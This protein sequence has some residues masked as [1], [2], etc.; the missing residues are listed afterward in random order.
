MWWRKAPLLAAA[1]LLAACGFTPVY[2]P[3]G[4]AL[5]FRGEVR[6][7]APDTEEEFAFN[8][9]IEQRLGRPASP[10]YDLAYVLVTEETGLAI[11]GSNNITRYS[12]EGTLGWTLAE[13]G[14]TVLRGEERAFTAYSATGSTIS[15]LESE[16]DARRRLMVILADRVVA[17][18]LADGA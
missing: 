2:G 4:Q 15:T 9:R 1:A 12:V 8:G 11:D 10:R 18:L 13:E 6:A 14:A 7:Q 17:R 5:P 16:R 3:G